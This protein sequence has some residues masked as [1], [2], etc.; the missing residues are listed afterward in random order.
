MMK[1][2]NLLSSAVVLATLSGCS[3]FTIGE[4]EFSCSGK[5]DHG[6]CMGP[7]EVYELTN[8]QD[9]LEHMMMDHDDENDEAHKENKVQRKH[10]RS[11]IADDITYT[12]KERSLRRQTR[13]DYDKAEIVNITSDRAMNTATT[14]G[15]ELDDLRT[16]NYGPYDIAPEPLAVLE[17][18]KAMRI[19]VAAWED[20]SGDLNIP[21][22]VYVELKERRWV[23]GHQAQMRPSRVL[24][25]QVIQKSKTQENR[26]KGMARGVD[27]LSVSRPTSQMNY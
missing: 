20:K 8:N 14:S 18:A 5:P 13:E 25:F 2:R 27:P 23:S 17:E 6:L 22:F 7:L 26:K 10:N 3:A 19:Y 21:G 9:N 16:Y 24:P 1:L 12:Y 15:D 4:E 11:G